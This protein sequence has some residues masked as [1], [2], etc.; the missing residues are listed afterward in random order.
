[1]NGI[2]GDGTS[3]A[4]TADSAPDGTFDGITTHVYPDTVADLEDLPGMRRDYIVTLTV[5]DDNPD[6]AKSDTDTESVTLSLNNNP[7][8]ADPGGPYTGYQGVPLALS[9]ANSYDPDTGP[10]LYNHIVRYEWELDG[11]APYDF[12]DSNLSVATWTWPSVGTFNVGLRVTDRF[13][14]THTKWT[15]VTIEEGVPTEIE[16]RDRNVNYSDVKDL[17]ARLTTITGAPLA[18]MPIRFYV[19]ENSDGY[20]DSVTEFA[21][22]ALTNLDGRALLPYTAWLV[23]GEYGVKTEFAGSEPYFASFQTDILRV[24]PEVTVLT[25]HGDVTGRNAQTASLSATLSDDEGNPIADRLITFAIGAQDAAGWTFGDGVASGTVLLNQS[26]G[27][28]GVTSLFAGDRYYRLADASDAFEI[29]N[30]APAV[31]AGA[32]VEGDEPFATTVE[33]IF[34]DPDPGQSHVAVIDWGDGTS[35]TIDPATSPVVADHVYDDS[36]FYTVTVTVSDAVEAGTDTLAVTVDNVPPVASIS[37][38]TD[39]LKGAV[40]S[41]TLGALDPSST[42]QATGFTYSIDWDGDGTVDETTEPGRPNEDV[43]SH[44]FTVSGPTT[45][46]LTAMDKDGGVSQPV[47]WNVNVIEPIQIDINPF[48]ISLDG[49]GVVPVSIYTTMD[50]NA[51]TIDLASLRLGNAVAVHAALADLD[52]DGDLDLVVH[53]RRHDLLDLYADLLRADRDEDGTIDSNRQAVDLALTGLTDD[54]I[55]FFGED[56]VELFMSGRKF[57]DF[58]KTL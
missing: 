57:S 29:L 41:F 54:G 27:L 11:E 50:F 44:I 49:N 25:Y 10:P 8:V 45:V 5:V 51:A 6:G 43:V 56:A 39:G 3:Y 16:M 42:D 13:G 33:A 4:E 19:D 1:M 31:A 46:I 30:T 47:S 15:T 58:V 55:S 18:D 14:D 24:S 26:V 20:F 23:P 28:Y 2:S 40:L 48:S 22:T 53:F 38:S 12:D 36:G 21:G 32:D 35:S 17:E 9:G 34:V 7:P 37:G 52:G